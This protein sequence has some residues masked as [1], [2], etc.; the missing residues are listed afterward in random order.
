V[1][2][3]KDGTAV[4]STKVKEATPSDHKRRDYRSI[5]QYCCEPCLAADDAFGGAGI[6][7]GNSGASQFQGQRRT[8]FMDYMASVD[9]TKP[10]E[11]SR[12]LIALAHTMMELGQQYRDPS[13]PDPMQPLIV[14]LRRDGFDWDGNRISEST[15]ALVSGAVAVTRELDLRGLHERIHAAERKVESDPGGAIGD[16]KELVE[17]VFRTVAG[18]HGISIDSNAD[19][20]DMFKAVREVLVVVPTDVTDPRKADAILRRLMGNLSGLCGSIAELRNAYGSGHGKH[21]E[22]VG[23]EKKHARLA[24]TTAGALAAFVLECDPRL[25]R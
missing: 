25:R 7:L 15:G 11:V 5:S 12:L 3:L 23:L 16:A 21:N 1:N 4:Q 8:R 20:T 17:A 13:A 2:E 22:F 10:E 19:V 18:H 6:P 24:V 9:Q 14:N